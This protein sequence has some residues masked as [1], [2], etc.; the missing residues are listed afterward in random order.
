MKEL[1]ESTEDFK[2]IP[3]NF[4]SSG[5]FKLLS[6]D[7]NEIKAELILSDEKELDDYIPQENVEIFG[8][9][10]VGLV[11]FETKII[12]KE[13]NIITLNATNDYSLIQR[14]EYSR[15]GLSQGKVLFKD[16]PPETILKIEDISAGGIKLICSEPL[17]A[18]KHYSIEI[19]HLGYLLVSMNIMEQVL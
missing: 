15:V 6:A 1:L 19:V 14:R 16:M 10:K 9:N 11:Y 5:A 17:E 3:N 12:A 18:D 13:G 2:I 4:K 8:V 7:D